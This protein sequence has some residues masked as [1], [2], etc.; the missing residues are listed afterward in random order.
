MPLLFISQAAERK[1][2]PG[3]M[4]FP[5]SDEN[6]PAKVLPKSLRKSND[7]DSPPNECSTPL[8]P[9]P[10]HQRANRVLSIAGDY[11]VHQNR[12]GSTTI[13]EASRLDGQGETFIVGGKVGEGITSG[14]QGIAGYKEI[15]NDVFVERQYHE[16]DHRIPD[17][18]QGGPYDDR[19]LE[20]GIQDMHRYGR[21]E[22]YQ[23]RG[24]GA[25]NHP[26]QPDYVTDRDRY[27]KEH[28]PHEYPAYERE[29]VY[30]QGPYQ[31]AHA[32]N[33][34]PSNPR[35]QRTAWGDPM[36]INAQDFPVYQASHIVDTEASLAFDAGSAAHYHPD[37]QP[38]MGDRTTGAEG[39]TNEQHV[40]GKGDFNRSPMP[41]NGDPG[42]RTE[43]V[44]QSKQSPRHRSPRE[45]VSS[46]VHHQSPRTVADPA[47]DPSVF[48]ETQQA[49]I[50]YAGSDLSNR[51]NKRPVAL[52]IPSDDSSASPGEANP[53]IMHVAEELESGTTV[54][55]LFVCPSSFREIKAGNK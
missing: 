29:Q 1:K 52:V 37:M 33:D 36:K 34:S 21:P 50:E 19:G 20:I 31:G 12:V 17:E 40:L 30:N 53:M 35:S 27:A 11:P 25:D 28:D 32:A 15:P 43:A 13:M 14:E 41:S 2:K 8:T 6:D 54:S 22:H 39:Y 42:Y 46:T 23:Q 5:L 7:G 48:M 3:L 26:I 55:G 24:Y 44:D 4:F 9:V 38:Y 47:R 49:G 10:T 16:Y 18:N 51:D 45:A